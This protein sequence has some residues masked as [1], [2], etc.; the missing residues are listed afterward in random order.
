MSIQL[1][2]QYAADETVAPARQQ[3]FDWVAVIP[4]DKKNYFEVSLRIVDEAEMTALNQA[5]RGKNKSTNVLAFPADIP[6]GVEVN[7]LGDVVI[8][9]PEVQREAAE[10]MKPVEAHWAHLLI[11][12]ILHLQGYDHINSQ[13][14]ERMEKKEIELLAA[15]GYPN[16]YE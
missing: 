12:G 7:L 11:H 14:A 10:Q 2:I 13:D 6:P 16:P 15:L 5:Y 3:F 8:C 4:N 1:E 9:L